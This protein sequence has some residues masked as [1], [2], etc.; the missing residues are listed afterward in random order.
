MA[1]VVILPWYATFFR[2]DRFEQALEEIAPIAL[3]YGALDYEILRSQQDTYKFMQLSTWERKHDFE[4]YWGGPEFSRWRADHQSWYQVLIM[5][6]WND[7]V[8]RDE[9]GRMQQREED[10]A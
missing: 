1:G 3:R 10:V 9:A 5:P 6:E 4:A 2:G 7:R 8:A